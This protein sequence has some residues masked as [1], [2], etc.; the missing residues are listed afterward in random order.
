[1]YRVLY[2]SCLFRVRLSAYL[3][4]RKAS[5]PRDGGKEASSCIALDRTIRVRP[6]RS[7]LLFCSLV[8]GA[9][10]LKVI[11]SSAHHICKVSPICLKARLS[12]L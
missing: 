11:P 9:R 5:G 8:Y 10:H 3:V 6:D 4:V 2:P 1:M 7:T 12:S